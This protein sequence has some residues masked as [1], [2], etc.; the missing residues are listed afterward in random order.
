MLK[1]TRVGG[2][3][4]VGGW[5][6]DSPAIAAHEYLPSTYRVLVDQIQVQYMPRPGSV[7]VDKKLMER[8]RLLGKRIAEAILMPIEQVK[9]LGEHTPGSCPVCHCK[10]LQIPGKLSESSALSARLKA[11]W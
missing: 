10:V 4:G 6:L 1:K 9:Y 7:L 5:R 3:I 2:L 8:A 11:R